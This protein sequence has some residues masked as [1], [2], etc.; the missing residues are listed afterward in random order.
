MVRVPGF[1]TGRHQ[2]DDRHHNIVT[3]VLSPR[4]TPP[5]SLPNR[6]IDAQARP[7]GHI[8]S[9]SF[10]Q[11]VL[12]TYAIGWLAA[13]SLKFRSL[14]YTFYNKGFKGPARLH[15]G[16]SMAGGPVAL[17]TLW[18]NLGQTSG[19]TVPMGRDREGLE[20]K[21]VLLRLMWGGLSLDGEESLIQCYY[22]EGA[23]ARLNP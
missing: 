23:S 12:P 16:V 11:G 10:T 20:R 14:C 21:Q 6:T 5:C 22:F 7:A 15:K 2:H 19:F 4:L 9:E 8:R 13:G 18:L 17:K 1:R 3:T